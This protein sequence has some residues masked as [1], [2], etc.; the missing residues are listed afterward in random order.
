MVRSVSNGLE[1][2]SKIVSDRVCPNHRS[3]NQKEIIP[4]SDVDSRT[5]Y[6]L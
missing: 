3:Y 4:V 2:D 6:W 5:L 1:Q